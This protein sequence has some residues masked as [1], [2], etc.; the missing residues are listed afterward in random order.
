M[1]KIFYTNFDTKIGKIFIAS[2]HS[3]VSRISLTK[4]GER[5]EHFFSW[6]K[7]YY[8]EHEIVEDYEYNSS[9][10]KQI[11]DYLD[12]KLKDFVLDLDMK[13]TDF[14]ISVWK[15][16]LK[17]PYGEIRTYKNIAEDIGNP[18]ASRA[19]GGAN[20]ANPFSIVVPCHRVIG[21]GGKLTG[22][23]GKKGIPVKEFLLKLEG[24]SGKLLY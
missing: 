13:G 4:S 17:I 5:E 23:S 20:R 21:T 16:L 22:Y 1:K 12:G 3:G 9:G 2:S 15:S 10:V 19:V 7:N 18:G 8:P 24:F 14:Q 11:L 6:I